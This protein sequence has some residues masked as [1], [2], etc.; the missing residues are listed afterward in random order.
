MLVGWPTTVSQVGVIRQ[1]VAL[2]I[3]W[4]VCVENFLGWSVPKVGA[5]ESLC[6]LAV[7][8]QKKTGS[9]KPPPLSGRGLWSA[10]RLCCFYILAHLAFD[11][12]ED[13]VQ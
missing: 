4:R 7:L 6:W 5:K 11:S 9:K 10:S 12:S 8:G 1:S 13:V 3:R 2:I